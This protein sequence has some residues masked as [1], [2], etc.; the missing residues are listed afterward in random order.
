MHIFSKIIGA[1]TVAAAVMTAA[2]AAP[3]CS[4]TINLG[5]DGSGVVLGSSIGAGTCI[6]APDKVW[7]NFDLGNLPG[8]TVLIFNLNSIGS[9]DRHQLSFGA[10]YKAGTTY[11]WSYEVA[12]SAT[13][14]P[15]TVITSID[16]DFTQ[17]AGGPSTLTKVLNPTGDA[18]IS[19]TKIGAIVQDG[20]ILVANFGE[21]ITEL[22]VSEQLIDDGTISSVTNAITQFIPGRNIPE[23]ATLLLLGAGLLGLG[24]MKRWKK[25]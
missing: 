1:M 10:T 7:G 12:V 2:S 24:S 19:E 18:E 21:G 9:L 25:R 3:T 22:K 14:A 17:T 13:A 23:P 8:D 15:G 16:T 4:T 6:A 20:S 5:P 11:N